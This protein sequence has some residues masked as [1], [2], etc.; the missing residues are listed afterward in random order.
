MS[1]GRGLQGDVRAA[2]STLHSRGLD[3]QM[4]DAVV[5][6]SLMVI[7]VCTNKQLGMPP[8]KPALVC[9]LCPMVQLLC[10]FVAMR[11]R[12]RAEDIYRIVSHFLHAPLNDVSGTRKGHRMS[13]ATAGSS[14]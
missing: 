2:A 13:S 6:T 9:A 12:E 3:D 14:R 1:I 10:A 5:A 4:E 7:M 11:C 8:T